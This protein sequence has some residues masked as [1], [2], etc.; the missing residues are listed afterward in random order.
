MADR[1]RMV[2]VAQ[3]GAPHGIKGE[4]RLKS[5][6]QTPADVAAYGPLTAADGRV[7]EIEALRPAA[8]SSSPEMFVVR[9][10]GVRDRDA[11]EKLTRLDLSV[12]ADRLPQTE[13]DEFYHADLV[14]LAAFTP[15]GGEV[16][17][18]IA[19]QNYGAGDLIEIAPP[20]GQTVLVPFTQSAVPEIDL[21]G[22]RIVV[23]PPKFVDYGEGEGEGAGEGGAEGGQP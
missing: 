10:K 3:F 9:L 5:F 13:A 20:R 8:G 7:F 22:R 19:V 21:A 14:G 2:V 4:V 18:V 11:A 6:T 15:E 16:G 23:V 12:A 1:A 17:T